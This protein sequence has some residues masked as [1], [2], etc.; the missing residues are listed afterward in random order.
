MSISTLQILRIRSSR[1]D[2][3]E[4]CTDPEAMVEHKFAGSWKPHKSE[5]EDE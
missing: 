2:R 3:S 1:A 4:S 5:D